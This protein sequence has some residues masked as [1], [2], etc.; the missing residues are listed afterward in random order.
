MDV[1]QSFQPTITDRVVS[2][3]LYIKKTGTPANATLR[4][5]KDSGGS[6]STNGGD[7]LTTAIINA[8]QVTGSY[9]WLTVSFGSTP[10]LTIN[11]TYWLVLDVVLDNANYFVWGGDSLSGYARGTGKKSQDYTVG[12][13]S[14]IG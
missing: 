11:T 14:D 2:A 8:S 3:D 10:T 12:F 9:G 1:A 6:P 5:I 4:L 7:I 13:W